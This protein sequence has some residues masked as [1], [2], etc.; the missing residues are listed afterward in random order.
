MDKKYS[1]I[2]VIVINEK[3]KCDYCKELLIDAYEC[4]M[5]KCSRYCK[6][7]LPTKCF[8]CG[9]VFDSNKLLNEEIR[10]KYKIKCLN[11]GEQMSLNQFASHQEN[12]CQVKNETSKQQDEIV[13]LRRQIEKQNQEIQ[14]DRAQLL[15][16]QQ[17]IQFQSDL[18]ENQKLKISSLESEML[19]KKRKRKR[20]RI[21]NEKQRKKVKKKFSKKKKK[22]IYKKK[23]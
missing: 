10:E 7:H 14:R 4:K 21:E 3:D 2:R 22:K 23:K 13:S 12:A 1:P 19:E 20:K 11:C 8:K 16:L 18:I 15:S 5:N 17:Q 9:G 6:N